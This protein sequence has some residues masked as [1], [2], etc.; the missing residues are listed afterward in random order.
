MVSRIQKKINETE[1]R[2]ETLETRLGELDT[3]LCDPKNAADM[4]LVNEYTDIQQ[5]L[6]KEM[7]DWEKLSEQLE[8]V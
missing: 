3:M 5:R 7:A 4:A 2:I 1:K 8:T 6:D